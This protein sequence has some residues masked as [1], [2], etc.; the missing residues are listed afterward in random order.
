MEEEA[1]PPDEPEKRPAEEV[2]REDLG[3]TL[4]DISREKL[5]R[6]KPAEEPAAEEVAAEEEPAA[7]P[8]A[9]ARALP[10]SR[11]TGTAQQVRYIERATGCIPP[12]KCFP[13]TSGIL[14]PPLSK[15]LKRM[16]GSALSGSRCLYQHTGSSLSRLL[17]RT[18]RAPS[19]LRPSRS[20]SSRLRRTP[21]RNG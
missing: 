4:R 6:L 16:S 15:S 20:G 12:R 5:K 21:T 3:D 10:I 7:I 9:V 11:L 8:Q 19:G 14:H 18:R 2:Q 1:P 13:G 17:P